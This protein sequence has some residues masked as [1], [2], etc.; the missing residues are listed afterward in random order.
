[1]LF[2]SHHYAQEIVPPSSIH[3]HAARVGITS[4]WKHLFLE[5]NCKL[6]LDWKAGLRHSPQTWRT[7]S[8][9]E[10]G[11]SAMNRSEWKNTMD[12]W[13]ALLKY[14]GKNWEGLCFWSEFETLISS[15][16]TVFWVVVCEFFH[17]TTSLLPWFEHSGNNTTCPCKLYWDL[18]RKVCWIDN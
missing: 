9:T 10:T 12:W 11:N 6:E 17:L 14:K 2:C 15:H 18:P 3:S 1:M 13:N 5:Q 7:V 4:H 8:K 16:A